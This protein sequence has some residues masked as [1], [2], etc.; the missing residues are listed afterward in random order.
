[1]SRRPFGA[2]ECD[3]PVTGRLDL[4]RG[5]QR[6]F[7]CKAA[8]GRGIL[9]TRAPTRAGAQ[10]AQWGASALRRFS[11]QSAPARSG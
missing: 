1:M 3:V 5:D 8:G 2:L 9:G 7:L 10:A 4:A 6:D 11:L